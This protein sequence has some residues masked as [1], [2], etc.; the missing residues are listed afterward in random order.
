VE[1]PSIA[2]WARRVRL[3]RVLGFGRTLA[4]VWGTDRET[5]IMQRFRI[6]YKLAFMVPFTLGMFALRLAVLT[7]QPVAPV[8]EYRIRCAM[9]RFWSR[10]VFRAIGVRLQIEGT[11]PKPP[12]IIV[13]NHLS[14]ADIVVLGAALGPAYVSRADVKDWPVLGFIA[15][16]MQTLFIDRRR[17]RDT[18]RVNDQITE[19]LAKGYGIH[20]FAEGGIPSEPRLHPFRPP[21]FEPAVQGDIPV[22]YANI[23]YRTYEGSP[24]ASEM[25]YWVRGI[26]FSEHV[27][28][29]FRLPGFEATVTFGEAPLR[30]TD[31]KTLAEDLH[32][33]MAAI[34]TP[35][36]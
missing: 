31:R 32:T 6:V 22:H 35:I 16:R 26:S 10:S 36:E 3:I 23:D 9:L 30:G 29:L 14:D 24:P 20:F 27:L 11:P 1:T 21:L 25:V 2:H 19:A 4:Q 13:S 33:A 12:Y 8:L 7:L 18:K 28:R 34:N 5:G 17:V 15:R